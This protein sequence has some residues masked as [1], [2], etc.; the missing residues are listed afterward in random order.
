[1]ITLANSINRVHED[2]VSIRK[3]GPAESSMWN[4]VHRIILET[5]KGDA[6]TQ[7]II[8]DRGMP[9]TGG[10][11]YGRASENDGRYAN[12]SSRGELLPCLWRGNTNS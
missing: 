4:P 9:G 3:T 6:S 10:V 2:S 7:S 8:E 11:R 12:I 1:V 5:A